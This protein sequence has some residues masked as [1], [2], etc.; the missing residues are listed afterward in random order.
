MEP[1]S[2]RPC[3]WCLVRLFD[4]GFGHNVLACKT[5]V[6]LVISRREQAIA[7]RK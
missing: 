2:I 1:R 7:K 4:F 6:T 5:L 3:G